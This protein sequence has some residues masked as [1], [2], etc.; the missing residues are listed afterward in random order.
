M[1]S[2]EHLE[3]DRTSWDF[4]CFITLGTYVIEGIVRCILDKMAF[5]LPN[6]VSIVREL[7][8]RAL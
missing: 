3:S 2:G 1:V 6:N 4:D 7:E 8:P 5:Q